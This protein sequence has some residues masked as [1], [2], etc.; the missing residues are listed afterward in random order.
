[1]N[2]ELGRQ[3]GD[4]KLSLFRDEDGAVKFDLHFIRQAPKVGQEYQGLQTG[5]RRAGGIE[6]YRQRGQDRR[7]GHRIARQGR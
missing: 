5:G 4:A 3:E 1:M 7:P 2:T 6:P